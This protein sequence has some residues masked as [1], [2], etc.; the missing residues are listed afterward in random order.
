MTSHRIWPTL[1]LVSLMIGCASPA[2]VREPVEESEGEV[3]A[4]SE[5][6][7]Y[8]D[9][10]AALPD[11][12]EPVQ[13]YEIPEGYFFLGAHSESNA[14][15]LGNA[16][17]PELLIYEIESRSLERFSVPFV[18]RVGV[19]LGHG[20]G[21]AI[22]GHRATAGRFGTY[23]DQE[24]LAP[25][26]SFLIVD[27]DRSVLE[28]NLT[29]PIAATS[30]LLIDETDQVL[31]GNSSAKSSSIVFLNV[32][33]LLEAES[34]ISPLARFMAEQY[35]DRAPVA[36]LILDD[37]PY[38]M[39]QVSWR[40]VAVSFVNSGTITLLDLDAPEDQGFV[41]PRLYAPRSLISALDEEAG[42]FATLNIDH[43]YAQKSN[44]A[45][46]GMEV[47]R[48]VPTRGRMFYAKSQPTELP[49]LS[50]GRAHK[51][52]S[53]HQRWGALDAVW[54]DDKILLLAGSA[55]ELFVTVGLLE[56]GQYFVV[57]S[58]DRISLNIRRI[59]DID[60][61]PESNKAY[62]SAPDDGSIISIDLEHL[63]SL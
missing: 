14:L 28:K 26:S 49:F 42:L 5:M 34:R 54:I 41:E 13:I 36:K 21:H 23:L 17:R 60:I 59:S 27:S 1:L 22:F 50:L 58:S 33:E 2:V 31:I 24:Y 56:E 8:E 16:T 35:Y 3:V 44:Q 15:I 43:D 57:E 4:E 25:S 10:S 39:R 12:P 19:D 52:R 6:V 32:R 38:E 48:V 45:A 51:F 61:V 18:P 37:A 55:D 46:A 7:S 47:F 11:T 30:G 62:V 20:R 63:L 40:H 53:P 29:E 9:Y